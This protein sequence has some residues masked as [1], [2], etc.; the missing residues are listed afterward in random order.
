MP[1]PEGGL[2]RRAVLGLG[3]ATTALLLPLSLGPLWRLD[4]CSLR[5]HRGAQLLPVPRRWL[6]GQ[7]VLGHG[8]GDAETEVLVRS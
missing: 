3:S 1:L 4:L 2:R 8:T 7:P 5:P 6:R